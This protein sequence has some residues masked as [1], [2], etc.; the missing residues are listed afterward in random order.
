[1]QKQIK[2]KLPQW[3]FEKDNYTMEMQNDWDSLLSTCLLK[4]LNGWDI[5]Y[6]YNFKARYIL[7]NM[8][9]KEKVG[10]DLALRTGKTV[11]NH[12]MLQDH[13]TV[14]NHEAVNLNSIRDIHTK[15]YKKKYPFSTFMLLISIFDYQLNYDDECLI[16]FILCVDSAYKGF[17]ADKDEYR[18]IYVDWMKLLGL[19]KFLDVL[20]K[21]PKEEFTNMLGKMKKRGTDITIDENGC[22]KFGEYNLEKLSKRLG[23]TVELPKG[24]FKQDMQFINGFFE[25]SPKSSR[26]YKNENVYSYA[27]T[28]RGSGKVSYIKAQ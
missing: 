14:K 7:D 28:K 4:H 17:Y 9:N 19:D 5:N 16:K 20:E 18:K 10:V 15:Q 11:C 8:N 23:F 13:S 21:T 3:I 22:L 25:V 2:D 1:M 6:F 27:F 26:F 24:Q 12:V